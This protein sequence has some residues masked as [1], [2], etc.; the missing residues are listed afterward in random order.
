MPD[1]KS[2]SQI[3]DRAKRQAKIKS[4]G[5]RNSDDF[6]NPHW[7]ADEILGQDL[8]ETLE[9]ATEEVEE[10]PEP[11]KRYRVGAK[12][13]KASETARKDDIRGIRTVTGLVGGLIAGG[14]AASYGSA[15]TDLSRVLL[16]EGGGALTGGLAFGTGDALISGA[17]GK[18]AERAKGDEYLQGTS[19]DPT[20]YSHPSI[21]E[22]TLSERG[23]GGYG[24]KAFR[25]GVEWSEKGGKKR[26][27]RIHQRPQRRSRS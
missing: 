8:S 3:W 1:D 6:V 2:W 4:D 26:V 25:D 13:E 14:V 15:G 17:L 10:A 12:L 11:T 9:T 7:T 21:I 24:F 18:G 22:S 27:R 16:L 23:N 20:P 19:E 5:I